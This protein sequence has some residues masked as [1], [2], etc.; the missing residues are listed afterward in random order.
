MSEPSGEPPPFEVTAYCRAEKGR[1]EEIFARVVALAGEESW[2]SARRAFTV[3]AG[4]L[5]RHIEFA[6]TVLFP[7]FEVKAGGKT[8]LTV[9]LMGSHRA[10]RQGLGQLEACLRQGSLDDLPVCVRTL[11]DVVDEHDGRELRLLCPM[12]D[13]LL[14]EAERAFLGARLRGGGERPVRFR[15]GR[16]PT[17]SRRSVDVSRT[18]EPRGG[19]WQSGRSSR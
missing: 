2:R 19:R 6:E 15:A 5:E 11:R 9:E 12:I 17:V 4:R 3:L 10:M 16:P 14:T 7:L 1:T 18:S 13:R 8:G